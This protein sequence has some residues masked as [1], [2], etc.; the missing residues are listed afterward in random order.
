MEK[1]DSWYKLNVILLMHH[2]SQTA[3]PVHCIQYLH[4]SHDNQVLGAAKTWHLHFFLNLPFVMTCCIF[5]F[6]VLFWAKGSWLS[7]LV[8]VCVFSSVLKST[9]EAVFAVEF[10]PSDSTNIITCGKSHVYFWTLSAGQFTKKQGIFGVRTIYGLLLRKHM[11][12][13]DAVS[14]VWNKKGKYWS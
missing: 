8:C 12:T 13:V 3:G 10:N 1:Y 5:S 2:R 4:C 9:N 6:L 7:L 11:A 14:S